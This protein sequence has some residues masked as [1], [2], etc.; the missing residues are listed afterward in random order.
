MCGCNRRVLL[1]LNRP[2]FFYKEEPCKRKEFEL[3]STRIHSSILDLEASLSYKM[4]KA[5]N[6]CLKARRPGT[7]FMRGLKRLYVGAFICLSLKFSEKK[8]KLFEC[9]LRELFL[10]RFWFQGLYDTELCSSRQGK[11]W[12][13]RI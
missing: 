3:I 8:M 7:D 10:R 5:W 11:V 12:F 4:M 2:R 1:G 9:V 13:T 6:W